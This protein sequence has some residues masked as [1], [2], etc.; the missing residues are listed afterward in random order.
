[1]QQEKVNE[2]QIIPGMIDSHF[3]YL[4][5]VK[6]GLD[7]ERLLEEC[8]EA[9]MAAALDIS[10]NVNT[11]GQRAEFAARFKNVFLSAGISPG[12]AE[13]SEKEIADMVSVLENQ[14]S[15]GEGTVSRGKII[16]VGETGLDWYWNYGTREKQVML[17]ERQIDLASRFSLPVII[18][19]RDADTDILEIL[20]RKTPERGG[21]IHCFS[22]GYDFAAKCIELGFLVSFA[23]NVTYKKNTAI[24]EAAK[25][26]PLVS[27]LAETDSPYLSPHN[28]RKFPSHPGFV[29]FT[30]RF[31]AEARG[32]ETEKLVDSVKEN[33]CSLFRLSLGS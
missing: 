2:S 3:H 4:E 30:Y 31:I 13:N 9:G 7:P 32:M 24:Q 22:S 6:K 17:F 8:L 23:G 15:G 19:N 5:M 12:K 1:M 27:I 18:H 25:K 16:A 14:L 33:F 28:V 29:S 26:I 11:L 20:K 21:I 10:T